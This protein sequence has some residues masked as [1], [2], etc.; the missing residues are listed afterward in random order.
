MPTTDNS[1]A[2]VAL[3]FVFSI[4]LSFALIV[5]VCPAIAQHHRLEGLNH[6]LQ[7][8]HNLLQHR[9][10]TQEPT[11]SRSQAAEQSSDQGTE[12]QTEQDKEQASGQ[13]TQDRID[14]AVHSDPTQSQQEPGQSLFNVF[15]NAC[16]ILVIIIAVGS[17]PV[18]GMAAL[19][20]FVWH[21]GKMLRGGKKPSIG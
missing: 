20:A 5:G 2:R 4:A 10:A 21:T 1:P 9:Q 16:E 18:C 19:C 15:L 7:S 3:A 12:Q 6:H 17:L 8:I 11:A 13:S 14:N